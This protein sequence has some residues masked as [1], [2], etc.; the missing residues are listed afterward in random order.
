[1]VDYADIL[2]GV[3]KEKRFVLESIYEDLRYWSG[4]FNL[5]IWTPFLGN[6]SS[7]EEE[8]IDYKSI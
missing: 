8:V 4:E 5:P 6:R 3:G 2:M 7:L 1:M